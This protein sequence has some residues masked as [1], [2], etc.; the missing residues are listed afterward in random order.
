MDELTSNS[1][2]SSVAFIALNLFGG[3]AGGLLHERCFE[4]QHHA[5]N[6]AQLQD[7]TLVNKCVEHLKI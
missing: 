1:L 4:V 2:D 7:V 5:S 6:V 3:A